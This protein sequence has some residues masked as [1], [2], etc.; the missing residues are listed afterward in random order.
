M[1]YAACTPDDIAFLDS[2]VAVD[3]SKDSKPVLTNDR[4]RN[5][6]I[7]TAWN[8]QKDRFNEKGATRFAEDNEQ[9][10]THF[11]SIDSLG[12]QDENVAKNGKRRGR[13]TGGRRP[14][15][16]TEK[17]QEALWNR[18]PCSSEQVASK[19]SLCIGMP[20]MIRR[21]DATELCITKGQE[22]IVVGW[23]SSAG[24]LGKQVLDTLFVKL[25]NPPQQVNLPDLPTNVVPLTRVSTRVTC[26][27][28]SGVNVTIQRQQVL[29]LPN[30]AMTDYSSQGKTREYNVVHLAHCKSH[31][32]YYTCLSR[33]SSAEGTVLLDQPDASK[34]TSGIHGS[35]RQEFRELNVLDEVTRLKYEGLLPDGIL[36]PLRNPTVQ[37]YVRWNKSASNEKSWHAALAYGPDENRVRQAEINGTWVIDTNTHLIVSKGKTGKKR[38]RGIS[39]EHADM[40][41]DN[42]KRVARSVGL[43]E[44][45]NLRGLI[46]DA[47][48]YSC[49]YDSIFTVLYNVW[50]RDTR[51]W[52]RRLGDI[53]N[54]LDM[55][56]EGFE[57]ALNSE[58]TLELARNRVRERIRRTNP[59][60]FPVGTR[61]TAISHIVESII[62]DRSCGVSTLV[63][64]VCGYRQSN[65]LIHFGERIELT[66]TGRFHDDSE[67][68]SLLSDVLGWQLNNRQRRSSRNCPDCLLQQNI[69]KLS[70]SIRF[71]RMPYLTM[72]EFSSPRYVIDHELEYETDNF[73][74]QF[75]LAGVIYGGQNHFVCRVVDAAGAVWYHDGI[76]TGGSC[77]REC[78]LADIVGDPSWLRSV[79]R[80]GQTKHALYA[81]YIRN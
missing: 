58:S 29:V 28:K 50:M 52:R 1:R 24:P 59:D 46:W 68:S 32:S 80:G 41:T 30:F 64:E 36:H 43:D 62:T 44:Y 69:S 39:E 21:N 31:M 38:N 54:N 34:I 66:S 47:E 15:K 78:K 20:V 63:C 4:F 53:S 5:V 23:D 56:C 73:E 11:Y 42:V 61:S 8:N 18:S 57:Q 48:N 79:E 77:V 9:E 37:A 13:A 65:P 72:V 2:R 25:V 40:S 10:L 22:A 27:L 60:I 7:I 81:I 3:L 26:S 51:L 67:E 33:S 14:R 71:E 17:L 16:M 74:I 19:L 49:A 35:L 75:K 55:L 76:T 6:S 45:G 12:A 70:I